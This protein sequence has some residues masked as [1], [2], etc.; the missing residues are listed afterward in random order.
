MVRAIEHERIVYY[1][2]MFAEALPRFCDRHEM[3]APRSLG[4]RGW[5]FLEGMMSKH[6]LAPYRSGRTKT[7]L[8]TK[9]LTESTYVVVGTD[10]DAKTGALRAL[11]AHN[12]GIGLKYAGAASIALNGEERR[13][14]LAEVERLTAFWSVFK[15]AR[16]LESSQARCA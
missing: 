7:W 5:V 4:D 15:S 8:K 16:T 12:D 10:R 6:V 9:C 1:H 2:V 13:V 11:L 3:L 14:F